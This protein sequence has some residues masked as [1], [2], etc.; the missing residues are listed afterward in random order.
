MQANNTL[1]PHG[2]WEVRRSIQL[3]SA[4]T[5]AGGQRL[6]RALAA[7]GGVLAVKVAPDTARI[8]LRYDITH[9]DYEALRQ[10]I[11]ANDGRCSRG[12][13]TRIKTGWYQYNDLT[14]RENAAIKTGACCNNLRATTAMFRCR[15][16]AAASGVKSEASSQ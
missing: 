3:A 2:A 6:T 5:Q 13:A 12:W 7:I 15:D 8:D 1:Q 14:G 4:P 10:A 9:T 16:S 11:E